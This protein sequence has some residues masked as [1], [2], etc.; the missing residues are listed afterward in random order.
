MSAEGRA[1]YECSRCVGRGRL[2]QHSNVLGGV[3]FQCNGSGKQVTKPRAPTPKWA[4]FFLDEQLQQWLRFY[5][6]I[7]RTKADAI[8]QAERTR[9]R[10]SAKW[11]EQHQQLRV[12]KWTD[13]ANVEALTWD[14][15]TK[16]IA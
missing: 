12:I 15:A 8:G 5:S 16:E 13:M 2:M 10:A 9:A 1:V 6:V 4:M 14:E 7:A 3:C 11:Q